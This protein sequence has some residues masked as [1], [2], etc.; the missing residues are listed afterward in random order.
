M[1]I[2]IKNDDGEIAYDV[3]KINS[4]EAKRGATVTI[5]KVGNLSTIIEALQFA[6]D[7][8]RGNLENL[9]KEAPEAVVTNE[10]SESVE[11]VEVVEEEES[12]DKS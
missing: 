10:D 1:I 7:A 3:N 9:L 6:S 4:E 8:H 12:V 2:T 5:S 11:D